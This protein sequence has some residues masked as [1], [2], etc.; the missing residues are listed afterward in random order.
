M[1]TRFIRA[2][3][4]RT[5][6]LYSTAPSSSSP[7][8][9]PAFARGSLNRASS[10]AASGS[11]HIGPF[12]LPHSQLDRDYLISQ[13]A[14][15]WSN[16]NGPQKLGEAAKQT[17]S[18]FVVLAGA[19]LCGLVVWA[20]G[21]E[22]FSENSPTRIFEDITERIQQD[23]ALQTILLPPYSFHGSTTTDR[24]RRNRRIAHSITHDPQTG[25][26][27]LFIRFTLSA[28]DPAAE[29]EAQEE[30]WLDWSKKWIGPLVWQDSH[31]PEQYQPHLSTDPK[32]VEPEIG[33]KSQ[34]DSRSQGWTGWFGG[35]V[36]A[37]F[38]MTSGKGFISDSSNGESGLF[39]RLRKPKL[40]EFSQGE[41][42]AEL[43]KDPRTNQFVYKQLFVAVPDTAT[44]SY[45]R[46]DI[47]TDIVVPS[48]EK[49]LDRLRIWQRSRTVVQ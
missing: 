46:H 40:G 4:V 24:M 6:R 19:G 10:A 45:Y 7:A 47:P 8:S 35:F 11:P 3:P 14:K 5:I 27:T 2:V 33:T 38:G 30:S 49:G 9:N 16:L 22:L 28:R 39:K 34:R 18:F 21:S 32:P 15:T 36:G 13:Q 37:A 17:S 42:V 43:Q 29:L 48:G 41:V 44:P 31:H 23:Q 12:P 20:V 26:E 25:L 1:S